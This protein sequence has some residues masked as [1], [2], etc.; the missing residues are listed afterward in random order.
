V[1]LVAALVWRPGAAPT[2]APTKPSRATP[3]STA[4]IPSQLDDALKRLEQAVQP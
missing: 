2:N 3:P 1:L 4:P